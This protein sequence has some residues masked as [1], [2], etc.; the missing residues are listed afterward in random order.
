[1]Y[2]NMYANM[3]PPWMW[4]GGQTQTPSVSPVQQI[5]DWIRGL[6]ELKKSMKDDKKDTKKNPEVSSIGLCLFM[7]LMAPVTGPIVYTF[8]QWGNHLLQGVR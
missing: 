4:P 1:M 5:T 3:P 8:F 2:P 7:L 6:E